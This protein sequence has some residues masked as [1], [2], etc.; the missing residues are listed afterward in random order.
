MS[1]K[2]PGSPPGQPP[3]HDKPE[4]D[5][6]L[7]IRVGL[8]ES[9]IEQIEHYYCL[10]VSENDGDAGVLVMNLREPLSRTFAANLFGKEKRPPLMWYAASLEFIESFLLFQNSEMHARH[11]SGGIASGKYLVVCVGQGGITTFMLDK[12]DCSS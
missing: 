11:K 2:S 4:D 10:W 1:R 12:P 3:G 5:E 8:V 6:G 9:T 7:E